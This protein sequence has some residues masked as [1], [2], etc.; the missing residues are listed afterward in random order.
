MSTV[1]SVWEAI[2]SRVEELSALLSGPTLE[3][4][5]RHEYQKELSQLFVLRIKHVVSVIDAGL[6]QWEEVLTKKEG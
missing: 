3:T 4:K 2:K 5:S 6:D 1:N